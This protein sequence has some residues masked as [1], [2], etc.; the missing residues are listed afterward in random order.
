MPGYIGMN[1]SSKCPYPTYGIKC[2]E[3][4]NCSKEACDLTTGCSA[5][6]SGNVCFV[7]CSNVTNLIIVRNK[8]I[9]TWKADDHV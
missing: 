8:I 3:I 5:A 7:L 4:C 9:W 6:I 2:Q 1:C